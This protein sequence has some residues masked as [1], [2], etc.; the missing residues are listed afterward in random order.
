MYKFSSYRTPL[1][2]RY[3]GRIKNMISCSKSKNVYALMIYIDT[4]WVCH[5][6][7]TLAW[8]KHVEQITEKH[9]FGSEYLKY[10][11]FS[12]KATFLVQIS[13]VWNGRTASWHTSK[14]AKSCYQNGHNIQLQFS[15]WFCCWDKVTVKR[16]KQ[17]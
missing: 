9:Q 3:L 6:N 12:D 4:K 7:Y 10:L 1:E 2:N 11:R 8:S 5:V 15:H 13:P 16:A 14:V 17:I